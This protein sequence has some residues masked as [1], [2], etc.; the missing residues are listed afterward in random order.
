MYYIRL[1]KLATMWL[2]KGVS[3]IFGVMIITDGLSIELVL[4]LEKVV[5]LQMKPNPDVFNQ[6][7]IT[8]CIYSVYENIRI[9]FYTAIP[10]IYNGAHKILIISKQFDSNYYYYKLMVTF[11]TKLVLTV[12]YN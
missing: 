7:E 10:L 2:N 5:F 1:P 3:N 8:L 4:Q 6:S 11:C 12:Y 9:F